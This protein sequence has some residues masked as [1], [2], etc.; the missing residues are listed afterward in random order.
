MQFSGE[1][2]SLSKT[3]LN[4]KASV[5]IAVSLDGYIA[6]QDGDIDWLGEPAEDGEDYGYGSFMESV[7]YLVMGRNTYDKVLTFGQWPYAKPVVVLT[8]RPLEQ[9]AAAN[10]QI[11]SISGTPMDVVQELANRGAKHLYVD[12]GQT[13]QSFLTANLIQHITISTIPVLIGQ[14]IPLFGELQGDI[15]LRH[16][17]TRSFPNSTVQSEYEV[18]P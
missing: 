11:E 6:R 1:Y 15:R 7:D 8:N 12:G 4:I 10:A 16:L 17:R 9:P 14:G 5:F 3:E 2:L 18:I 13:I